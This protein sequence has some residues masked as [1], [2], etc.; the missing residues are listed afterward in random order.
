MLRRPLPLLLPKFIYKVIQRII[1][2]LYLIDAA[3]EILISGQILLGRRM[4]LHSR[5]IVKVSAHL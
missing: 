4:V 3:K 2:Y 5:P 1:I